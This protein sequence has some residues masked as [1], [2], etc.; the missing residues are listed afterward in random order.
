MKQ[1]LSNYT[2]Y[3]CKQSFDFALIKELKKSE[4]VHLINQFGEELRIIVKNE[5]SQNELQTLMQAYI[6]GEVKLF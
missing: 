6:E 3:V 1:S 4:N 2:I 5:F